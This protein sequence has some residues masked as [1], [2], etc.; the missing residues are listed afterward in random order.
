METIENQSWI[1][2]LDDTKTRFDPHKCG[3][4]MYFF[5][6]VIFAKKICSQA[7]RNGIVRETKHSNSTSGVCCFYLHYD[8]KDAHKRVI[9]YF[10]QNGLIQK[11]KSGKLYNISF[12][13]DDQT[14]AGQYGAA[15]ASNIKLSCFVDLETGRFID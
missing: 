11:T 9:T 15:F 2:Y 12:K 4:W 8:D 14:R 10:L 7:V 1:Y 5:D 6:D 13:L 3:K